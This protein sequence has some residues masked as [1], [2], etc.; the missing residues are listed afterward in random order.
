MKAKNKS[1]VCGI[2]KIMN[3]EIPIQCKS[4]SLDCN[5]D[6]G[7]SIKVMGI[8]VMESRTVQIH[9]AKLQGQDTKNYCCIMSCWHAIFAISNSAVWLKAAQ[10]A[11]STLRFP[12]NLLQSIAS[13]N[14]LAD[15]MR[16]WGKIPFLLQT[17]QHLHQ[18]FV[19]GSLQRL[20]CLLRARA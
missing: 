19:T 11:R 15:C 3:T 17:S 5:N 7:F 12:H 16:R 13:R 18:I 9:D 8:K 6:S 14:S 10:S 20:Q 2:I 4:S 1:S